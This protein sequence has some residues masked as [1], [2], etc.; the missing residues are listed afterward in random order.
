MDE[1]VN[2]KWISGQELNNYLTELEIIQAIK[3]KQL[4]PYDKDTGEKIVDVT[5]LF[6]KKKSF[7]EILQEKRK[8]SA[9]NWC[10]HLTLCAKDDSG[11]YRPATEAEMAAHSREEY[12]NQGTSFVVLDGHVMHKFT[13]DLANLQFELSELKRSIVEKENLIKSDVPDNDPIRFDE[14]IGKS[15]LKTQCRKIARDYISVKTAEEKVP[16]IAEAIKIIRRD[17]ASNYT[18]R[19]I[20]NWITEKPRIFPVESSKKGRRKD[21]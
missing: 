2:D 5:T 18:E 1:T 11:H 4:T 20:R 8:E 15:K 6:H 14:T 16:I 9:Y 10:Y 19:Q 13:A 12:K 3:S 21:S 7:K 17:F